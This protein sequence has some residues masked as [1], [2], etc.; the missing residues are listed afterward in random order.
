M[1]IF[2]ANVDSLC[3]SGGGTKGIAF[4]GAIECLIEKN[5]IK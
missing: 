3:F 5:I 4:I 2:D 1:S